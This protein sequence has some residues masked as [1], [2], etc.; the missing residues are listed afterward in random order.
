MKEKWLY[1]ILGVTIAILVIR[2]RN[3]MVSNIIANP[4][5]VDT[6]IIHDTVTISN[7]VYIKERFIDTILL[8][9]TDTVIMKDTMYV[10]VEREQRLYQGREYQ[11]WV[12]GYRPTLDSIKIYPPTRY[13]TKTIQAKNKSPWALSLQVGYGVSINNNRPS[14]TPYIG[15]GISRDLIRF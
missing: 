13:I 6:L 2:S 10:A 14:G 11:A 8:P 7:P 12:S 1:L 15:I 4:G 5:M 3:S 9:I